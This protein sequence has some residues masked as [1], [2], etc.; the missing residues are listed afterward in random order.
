MI[1]IPLPFVV[2]LLLAILAVLLFVRRE[3]TT[4]SAFIF[5][6]LCALTTTVVGLRWT[7][8]YALL[9]LLQPI[10]VC[11]GVKEYVHLLYIPK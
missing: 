6:A 11:G 10:A 7:F 8:D 1:A 9:R 3:D 2:A 5:V 4:Q